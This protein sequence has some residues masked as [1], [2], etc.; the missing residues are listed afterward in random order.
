MFRKRAR[1]SLIGSETTSLRSDGTSTDPGKPSHEGSCLTDRKSDET[2]LDEV[3]KSMSIE[4]LVEPLPSPIQDQPS[5]HA[6]FGNPPVSLDLF[7]PEFAYPE[8]DK[9]LGYSSE[10]DMDSNPEYFALIQ[11][12]AESP[13]ADDEASPGRCMPPLIDTPIQ[14]PPFSLYWSFTCRS[15]IMFRPSFLAQNPC[16]IL[17]LWSMENP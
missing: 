16:C 14:N 9:N 1:E 8:E 6:D 3:N 7:F 2:P 4:L 5:F 12:S 17:L 10:G 13:E 15:Y 11:D